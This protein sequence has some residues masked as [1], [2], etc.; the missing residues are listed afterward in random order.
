MHAHV[1]CD[2]H[3]LCMLCYAHV[4]VHV[5][6]RVHVRVH[7]HVLSCGSDIAISSFSLLRASSGDP[8]PMIPLVSTLRWVRTWDTYGGSPDAWVGQGC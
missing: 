2:V 8:S 3:V 6:M 1:T 5:H 4:H 7:V